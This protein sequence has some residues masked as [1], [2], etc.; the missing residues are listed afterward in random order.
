MIDDWLQTFL[1]EQSK[2]YNLTFKINSPF[3]PEIQYR[4]TQ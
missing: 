1:S 2:I 3:L 4:L